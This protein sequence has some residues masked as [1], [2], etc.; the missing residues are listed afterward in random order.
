MTSARVRAECL[1]QANRAILRSAPIGPPAAVLLA[2]ILGDAV[3]LHARVALVAAVTVANIW[4]IA[5]TLLYRRLSRTRVITR[6]W[7]TTAYGLLI[8]LSW[9][10][11]ALVGFPDA[12]H[13]D[14]RAIIALFVC[15]VSATQIVSAAAHRLYF[16]AVQVPLLGI[17][18]LVYLACFVRGRLA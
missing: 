1:E 17:M 15:G 10:S 9:P 8:G 13:V 3:S 18:T 5:A 14:M 2:I 11:L 4:G 7:P 16:F 6:W 12:S